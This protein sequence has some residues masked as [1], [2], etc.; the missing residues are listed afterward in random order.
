MIDL[1]QAGSTGSTGRIKD[2]VN[3]LR[4]N[5]SDRLSQRIENQDPKIKEAEKKWDESPS[6]I[7]PTKQE[8]KQIQK[9][10]INYSDADYKKEKLEGKKAKVDTKIRKYK[11]TGKIL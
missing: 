5:R 3:K 4:E 2:M 7:N 9:A 6:G 10:Y 8:S 11:K 1:K